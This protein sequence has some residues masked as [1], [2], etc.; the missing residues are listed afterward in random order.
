[1][2]KLITLFLF[3]TLAASVGWAADITVSKT[4][5][6]IVSANG[7]TVSSGSDVT[8]YTSFALDDNITISTTGRPNCGSFWGTSPNI[9]WR[10]YQAKSGNAIISSNDGYTLK[11]VII[12]FNVSNSG[13]LLNG[14]TK[15]VSGTAMSLSGNSV[16]FTVSNTGSSY[17]DALNN[18]SDNNSDSSKVQMKKCPKCG[19]EVQEGYAFCDSCG[20]KL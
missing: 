13:C 8:C 12:T 20:A 3:A 5:N 6:E 14:S 17:Y 2:K 11:S 19:V 7:Y 15:V 9:D 18:S 16:T 4:I 10:L 1:M